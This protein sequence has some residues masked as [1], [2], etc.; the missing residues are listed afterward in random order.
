MQVSPK[1]ELDLI[2]PLLENQQL[3]EITALKS[4]RTI[5]GYHLEHNFGHGQRNLSG[6]FYYLNL[7]AYLVHIILERGDREFQKARAT[8][9]SR[10]S[11]W[12]E[13][14]T[15]MRRLVWESWASLME[16]VGT[17]ELASSP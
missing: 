5:D 9:H 1:A 6:V 10:V 17:E 15:L 8:V 3:T 11:F 7:L 14:R 4:V 2:Q 16:F 12:N 13:L